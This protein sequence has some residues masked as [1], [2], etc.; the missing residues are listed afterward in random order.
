MEKIGLNI[1]G[2]FW[3]WKKILKIKKIEN[4]GE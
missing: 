3:K 2:I 4:F 1:E